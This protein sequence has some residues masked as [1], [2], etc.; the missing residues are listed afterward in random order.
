[1]FVLMGVLATNSGLSRE[2][3]RAGNAWLGQLRG[4]LALATIGACA[5]FAAICGSSVAT[6]ATM[7]NIALPEMKRFGYPDDVSTGVIAAGGTLGILIPPSGGLAGY[8]FLTHQGGGC[9]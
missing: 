3:F 9:L 5:G 1:M 6:A 4:G 2:L 7:T 8:S